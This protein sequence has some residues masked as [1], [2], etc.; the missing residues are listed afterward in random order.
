MKKKVWTFILVLFCFVIA[1][2]TI[3]AATKTKTVT[4]AAKK[5]TVKVSVKVGDTLKIKAKNGKK[6]AKASTLKFTTSKKKIAT[7]NNKGVVKAKKAGTTVINVTTKNKKKKVAIKLTVKKKVTYTNYELS[8]TSLTI[9]QGQS[10]KI[11]LIGFPGSKIITS[12]VWASRNPAIASVSDGV[13]TGKSNGS[14]TIFAMH[15][16]KTCMCNVTVTSAFDIYTAKAKTSYV[17]QDSG[18]G[19][20]VLLTNNYNHAISVDGKILFKSTSGA[21]LEA[22]SDSTEI[23]PGRTAVML[24]S[25]PYDADYNYIKYGSVEFTYNVSESSWDM[26]GADFISYTANIGS[27]NVTAQFHNN[28]SKSSSYI[29]VTCLLYNSG[30]KLIGWDYQYLDCKNPGT[31]DFKSFSFPHDDDYNIIGPASYKIYVDYA[32]A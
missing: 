24:F 29:H 27:D 1:P 31:S 18:E 15:G 10:Q 4:L 11:N 21:M 20:A 7:V 26:T 22:V 2:Q 3:F 16:G 14:T 17:I 6:I 5:K 28:A 9:K 23:E 8:S 13:I 12:A 25:A 19:V 32:E 30:G